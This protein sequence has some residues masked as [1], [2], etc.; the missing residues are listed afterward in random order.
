MIRKIIDQQVVYQQPDK[1]D[2]RKNKKFHHPVLQ[3]RSVEYPFDTD[4]IINHQAGRKRDCS[5]Q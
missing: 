2:K 3:D 1:T 5:R 4:Q